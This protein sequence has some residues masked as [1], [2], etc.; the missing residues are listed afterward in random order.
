MFFEKIGSVTMSQQ[1]SIWQIMCNSSNKNNTHTLESLHIFLEP[2][3]KLVPWLK[4]FEKVQLQFIIHLCVVRNFNSNKVQ[5]G[6]EQYFNQSSEQ[7]SQNSIY[8]FHIS[9]NMSFLFS[10]HVELKQSFSSSARVQES[11]LKG[12]SCTVAVTFQVE[13]TTSYSF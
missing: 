13:R 5:C 11:V 12:G 7:H 3:Y 4:K 10:L 2:N 8:S 1:P 9:Q 6:S